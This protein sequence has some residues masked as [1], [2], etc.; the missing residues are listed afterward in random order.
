M[1]LKHRQSHQQHVGMEEA[2]FPAT[3]LMDA[4]SSRGTSGTSN[5]VHVGLSEHGM[6]CRGSSSACSCTGHCS[7]GV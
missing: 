3:S 2:H 5:P 4:V 1:T 7:H 6:H